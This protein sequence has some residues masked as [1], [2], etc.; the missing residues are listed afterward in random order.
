MAERLDG[1][2]GVHQPRPDHRLHV[3]HLAAD[4][5]H[6]HRE[7]VGVGQVQGA[8]RRKAGSR[9]DVNTRTHARTLVTVCRLV[10]I[11]KVTAASSYTIACLNNKINKKP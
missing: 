5:L 11:Q 1:G 3:E 10:L 7:E 8:L 9:E 6:Q 2:G 4:A